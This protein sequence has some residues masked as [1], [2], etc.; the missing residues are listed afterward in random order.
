M[1]ARLGMVA[2]L[3]AAALIA[4]GVASAS[5]MSSS[6]SNSGS[7]IDQYKEKCQTPT[8]WKLC[9]KVHKSKLKQSK[10]GLSQKASKALASTDASTRRELKSVAANSGPPKEKAKVGTVGTVKIGT[11]P[12]NHAR[13][14]F[15]SS[16]T[17]SLVP[18]GA[19]SA[20][21]LAV[22]LAAVIGI[23]VVTGV[24]AVRKQ[25]V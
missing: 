7:A 16:L 24:V 15:G 5:K 22:L 25:R 23:C 13:S 21:R 4:P 6:P 10:L 1:I 20:A 8:G 17:A 2:C 19:G 9:K 14:T 18:S 11:I 12:K 3:A